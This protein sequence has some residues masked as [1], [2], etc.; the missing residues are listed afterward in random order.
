MAKTAQLNLPLLM[1]SQAQ[2]HV[3]VNEALVRL[4]A[5]VQLRVESSAVLV[6]PELA[7]DG[8]SFLV[9]ADGSGPW[10]GKAG[11][12]AVWSNGGWIYLAPKPG[13]RVWD[14]SLGGYRIFDGTEWQSDAVAVSSGGAGTG[15]KVVEFDHEVV[16]GSENVTLA[17][18]PGGAQVLGVT[19]RVVVALTGSGLASWRIGVEGAENRYGSGIGKGLNSVLV[20]LSG[21]PVTYYAATPLLLTA[22]G[23]TFASGRIRLAIH[24]LQ[25]TPPRPV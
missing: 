24:L 17:Q 5:A 19:G 16:A 23:G 3:T 11:Q 22:E 10:Q 21:T 13:W 2:K 8:T 4:D 1:P 18:I 20:G 9:P 12:I 15:W 25:L 7:S 14:E 6:P